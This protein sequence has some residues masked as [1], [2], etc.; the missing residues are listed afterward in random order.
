MTTPR[1]P[2]SPTSGPV[3]SAAAWVG[4]R[5][6][7]LAS[8]R[9][10]V[11]ASSEFEGAWAMTTRTREWPLRA[12]RARWRRP[13]DCS[14]GRD[15]RGPS[16]SP[17][18]GASRRG[19]SSAPPAPCGPRRHR[20]RPW[21]PALESQT[22]DGSRWSPGPGRSRPARTPASR[23]RDLSVASGLHEPVLTEVP[24][25]A[26]DHITVVADRSVSD[27]FDVDGCRHAVHP[28]RRDHR[29]LDGAVAGAVENDVVLRVD[30]SAHPYPAV[31][32][33]RARHDEPAAP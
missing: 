27:V 16:G 7:L 21:T 33:H 12:G 20:R 3:G 4:G 1:I 6:C 30:Q 11:F 23:T 26:P 17:R 8:Q 31:G 32:A 13:R 25:P 24:V 2:L 10:A 28:V 22:R 14:E 9:R 15:Y 5:P 19:P 29:A 18:G